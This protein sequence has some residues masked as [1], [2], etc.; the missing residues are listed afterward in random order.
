MNYY[1]QLG[2]EQTA[3]K[4]DIKRAYFRLARQFTPEKNPEE[5]ILIRQAYEELSD[6]T[7]KSDYDEALKELKSVPGEVAS[8][9]LEAERMREK[10][11]LVDAVDLLEQMQ[12]K[13]HNNEA[14]SNTLQYYM[15]IVYL[16]MGKSGKAAGIAEKLVKKDPNNSKYLILA[17][18]ACKERGW[19]SKAETYAKRAINAESDDEYAI[20]TEI[21][22]LDLE[23]AEIGKK[24]QMIEEKGG[25]APLLCAHM[26][27]DCLLLAYM[28]DEDQDGQ[29]E[30][31]GVSGSEDLQ[32]EDPV[33]M[34]KKLVEH[35][36]DVEDSKKDALLSILRFGVLHGMYE[37][38]RFDI[39]PQVDKVFANLG[40]Y[41]LLQSEEY[42]A[43][44]MG[45]AALEA[46]RAGVPRM[47]AAHA[48]MCAFSDADICSERD[49]QVYRLEARCLEL[50]ILLRYRRLTSE[51]KRF[52]DEFKPLFKH[53]ADFYAKTRLY[54]DNR[55]HDEVY[56]YLS[57]YRL[58]T[59]RLTLSWLGE[60]DE[61]EDYVDP[62]YLITERH[63]PVRVTKIG[64]NEP[65]P[66]GSGLKY[67]KC[68]GK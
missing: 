22:K 13:Y 4:D 59:S 65:C 31:P 56:R 57:K 38:D 17:A 21:D 62:A 35:T 8:V 25:R 34:A 23:P 1:E 49:K 3:S 10:R 63:D 45:Y 27:A 40:E 48:V 44:S 12:K 68:C 30:I 29:M 18:A 7:K 26:L 15:C 53:A 50:D 51:I 9:I 58:E 20:L 19:M 37:A 47:L 36:V 43:L 16:D 14:V 28:S 42:S 41:E 54:N 64:R 46:V 39:L 32:W 33:F 55:L 24:V 61:M 11:L 60:D 52:Q 5:F 2:L 67:K 66:C 6:D